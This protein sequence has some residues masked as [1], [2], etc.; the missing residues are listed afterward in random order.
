MQTT[1]TLQLPYPE[2][3]DSADVPRDVKALADA[4]DA[5]GIGPAGVIQMWPGTAAPQGFYL[6][7]GQQVPAATNPKLA[8]LL[9]VAAGNVTLPDYRDAFPM[10]ASATNA[11]NSTGGAAQVA[12]ATAQLPAHNHGVNDPGHVHALDQQG[13]HSHGGQ[14]G[15]RDRSQSHGHLIASNAA[16]YNATA[17]TVVQWSQNTNLQN[18]FRAA[19]PADQTDPADH[20]H[21]IAI[22]GAHTHTAD[23]RQTGVSVQNAG[24]GAAHENRP[25]FRAINFIIRAG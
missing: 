18:M 7:N 4:L 6:C 14:T 10:G 16:I 23:L 3:A 8:A 9:G 19:M 22:D 21:T 24:G 2:A 13:A 25:P 1:P 20:L 5:L 11:L 17:G 15:A 12:L